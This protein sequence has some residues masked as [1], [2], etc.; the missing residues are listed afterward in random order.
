LAVVERVPVQEVLSM[1]RITPPTRIPLWLRVLFALIRRRYG[2]VFRP[3]LV[4]ANAPGLVV[5]FLLT[6]W[7]SHGRGTLPSDTRLLAMQLVG[8]LNGCAWCI[9][10]GRSLARDTAIAG[11]VQHLRE[12]ASHP[13]FTPAE[14]AALRY[15]AEASQVPIAVSDDSAAELRRHFSDRQIVELT[16]AIAI[17][18]FYNR[19]NAPLGIEAEG[20]CAIPAQPLQAASAS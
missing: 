1:T 10:F 3:L 17:E 19:V 7:I 13:S 16:F 15:A 12:F 6:N 20:F 14:R 18:S 11:K 4:A 5:P 9:D 2:R 8:E